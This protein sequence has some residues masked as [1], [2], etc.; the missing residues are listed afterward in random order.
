MKPNPE[1]KSTWPPGPWHSEPDLLVWTDPETSYHCHIRR[2]SV[3]ALCGYVGV[4]K[5]HPAF[6]MHY[7][8]RPD[9]LN[10]TV[11]WW[12]RHVTNWV[13]Y[14]I[15]DINVHG[16]LTFSDGSGDLWLFGF[17]CAHVFDLIPCGTQYTR[18]FKNTEV[19]R[20]IEYV[21]HECAFLAKQL[22]EIED[23]AKRTGRKVGVSKQSTG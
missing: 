12:R 19:Y 15:S 18:D 23:A 10:P 2:G 1:D 7:Y 11:E 8:D 21:K 16:G 14:K 17:D 3:G 9:D 5:N 4:A 13:Q 22:R 6:G 20:D